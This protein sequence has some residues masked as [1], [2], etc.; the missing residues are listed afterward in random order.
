MPD[1]ASTARHARPSAQV[2]AQRGRR[3]RHVRRSH[4]QAA[5]RTPLES[6]CAGG[7]R[8]VRTSSENTMRAPARGHVRGTA[9]SRLRE[10][11]AQHDHVGIEEVDD[12]GERAREPLLVARQ[13]RLARA[14]RPRPRAS[15]S[16]RRRASRR[17]PRVVGGERRPREVGLDAARAPAVARAAAGRS[18]PRG[19]GSGLWPH[20]P[21]IAFAPVST[22][23]STTMPPPTPVPRITPKTTRASRAAPSTA[24]ESA[25]QLASLAMRTSRSEARLEVLLERPAVEAAWSWS[26]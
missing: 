3:H 24:S 14:R 18:S 9:R 10:P 16:R 5:P 22:R 2:Q 13:R 21:A 26:S 4:S 20:S 25:K 1:H 17:S 7:T 11:A 6:P 23:R 12:D 8:R 15:R 19:S